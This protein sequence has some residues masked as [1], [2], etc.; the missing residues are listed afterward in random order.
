MNAHLATLSARSHS[1]RRCARLNLESLEVRD[2]PSFT[3]TPIDFHQFH[4]LR[5]QDLQPGMQSCPV[6]NVTLGGVPFSIPTSGSNTWLGAGQSSITINVGIAGVG[7]VDTLMNT[8][9]GTSGV[10]NASLEFFG[11]NGAYFRKD[12]VG[13]SDIRD[14]HNALWTNSINNTTTTNVFINGADR[15]DKQQITLP[16]EFLTQTLQTIRVNDYGNNNYG[17]T[18]L[19]S[20]RDAMLYGLTVGVD[21]QPDLT[22]TSLTWNTAQGGIDFGYKV[23]VAQL[24]QDTTAM[25]YWAT[26]TTIDT[27]LET[28]TTPIT[29]PETTPVDQVQTVHLSPDDFPGGPAPG[30]RYLI[31]VVDADNEID[32]G[33]QGEQNNVLPLAIPLAIAVDAASNGTAVFHLAIDPLTLDPQRPV[34]H[35]HALVTGVSP[36]AVQATTFTWTTQVYYHAPIGSHGRDIPDAPFAEVTTGPDYTP[37]FPRIRGGNLTFSVA[38]QVAGLT[39]TATQDSSGNQPLM[40]VGDNPTPQQIS[41]Y[42]TNNIQTPKEWPNQYQ[43]SYQ[44]IIR[45]IIRAETRDNNAGIGQFL[46]NGQP[47]WSTHDNPDA[48]GAGLMQISSATA[49]QVW[50]WKANIAGGVAVFNDKL[51]VAK[52][53]FDNLVVALMAEVEGNQQQYGVKHV[54]P[55]RITAN[56]LVED[57]IRGYNGYTFN[58]P[59]NLHEWR[60]LRDPQTGLLIL[61]KHGQAGEIQWERTPITLRYN[62]AGE[63][64]GD[65]NYVM[66]VLGQQNF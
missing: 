12:L 4:N 3:Y 35:A 33:S 60:P 29:I 44:T 50:N 57:A 31:A 34:V 40:I 56:M 45:K 10:N 14:H 28:A 1:L 58:S 26:G 24:A 37:Q 51:R 59:N 64:I 20:W 8:I 23:S 2:V 48:Y 15:V 41:S 13:G 30:A 61:K 52:A 5:I 21:A 38:A 62:S 42:I 47:F 43:D 17:G 49:D 54:I 65:P 7:E 55:P 25:L 11:S 16:A 66:V 36:G 18:P 46:N 6:G 39:F 63:P 9:Y 32:E 22:P 19:S 27:I 53:Y